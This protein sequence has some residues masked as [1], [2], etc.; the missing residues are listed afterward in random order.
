LRPMLIDSWKAKRNAIMAANAEK[1]RHVLD[2]LQQHLD[3]AYLNFQLFEKALELFEDDPST[4]VILHRHLLR[5]TATEITDMILLAL[6]FHRRLQDG[7]DE[8]AS[9]DVEFALLNS[10]QR[11]SL[12]KGLLGSMSTKAIKM[13]EALE[14]KVVEPFNTTLKAIAEESGLWLKKL[15]KKIERTLMHSY[16]KALASQIE[17][18]R[19]PVALLPKVVAFLY[20]QV[21]NKALQIPGRAI[22]IAISGLKDHI[23]ETGYTTLMEYHSATVKLIALLSAG[24]YSEDDCTADRI[25]SKR[26]LLESRMSQLKALPMALSSRT[27]VAAGG[28]VGRT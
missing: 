21:H 9:K 22:A 26:E 1:R 4:S 3:E 23:P 28:K 12:A 11:I 24:S 25:L 15:D 7:I 16:R 17:D 14:G 5:T 19:D 13:V 10:G 20:V 27:T 18:E 8:D 2:K 6:D